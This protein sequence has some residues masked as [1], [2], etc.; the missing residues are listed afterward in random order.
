MLR[1]GVTCFNDMYLKMESVAEAVRN[2][3]IRAAVSI[4][5]LLTEKRGDALVDTAGCKAFF[6]KWDGASDGL[7]HTNME[8]HS[9]Y[10]Y[11]EETLR[12]GARLAKELGAAIHIHLLETA[13]ER[14]NMLAKH[15]ES[16]VFLAAE[17]GLLDVPVIAAH[18]VHVDA[19]DIEL[20]EKKGVHVAHNPSSN[21]KLAS[22]V[23]PVPQLL[24]AGVNVCLGTD[25]ASSN[26]TLNLFQEMRLA[27]LLHKGASGDALAVP[28]GTAFRMATQNGAAALGF[29]DCGRIAPGQKADITILNMDKP[30][31]TP[32]YDPLSTVVYAA[33]ASDV[34]TVMVNGKLLLHN[35]T[36]RTM[37][38]SK[39]RRQARRIAEKLSLQK[40]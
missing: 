18:C 12:E 2:T 16:S 5:P 30:H 37:D 28:A 26:N 35:G 39:V 21:L 17:Y 6:R 13:T 32:V 20:L 25:G 19:A 15:K 38:E 8:I 23:A 36:L 40:T 34:E 3:G 7:I 9:I 10:L 24:R 27:A 22:G 4:G 31:L 14:A 33:Q 29:P 1:G 11:A